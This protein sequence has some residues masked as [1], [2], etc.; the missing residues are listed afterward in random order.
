MPKLIKPHLIVYLKA[1]P[2]TCMKRIKE[3]ARPGEHEIDIKYLEK[4][5]LRYEQ[6]FKRFSYCPCLTINNDNN[7]SQKNRSYPEVP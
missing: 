4:L 2:K 1:G 5:H 3:R 7:I 6:M